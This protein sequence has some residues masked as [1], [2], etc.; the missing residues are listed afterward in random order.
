MTVAVSAMTD[1]F[2]V[3]A[4]PLHP[5]DPD[6]QFAR[7]LRA[8][9]ERALTLPRGVAVSAATTAVV[10]EPSI[11][12]TAGGAVPYLA[13]EDARTAID[14][15]TEVLGARR[16]GE[17]IV[18]PDGRVGHAALAVGAGVLYL[19]DAHPEIG[20][21]APTPG[22]STVSLMLEVDD[23]DA[24]LARALNRGAR[25]DR[26]VYE[27]YGHRNAWIVDPFGH[28]WCLQG[29]ILTSAAK[30]TIQHGDVGYLMWQTPDVDA[31]AR[32]YAQ[33]LGWQ[34]RPGSVPDGRR[35]DNSPIDIG[36]WGGQAPSTAYPC[37]A[38]DSVDA[39]VVAV[40]AAGGTADEP[41]DAPH[42]RTADCV[43]DQGLGFVVYEP[44]PDA[45]RPV[46]D[47]PGNVSYLSFEVPSAEAA[48]AF[49]GAVLGWRP[50]SE[51]QWTA[52]DPVPMHGI[53]GNREPCVVP[54]WK[55]E[56]IHAAVERVRAG[57]GTASDPEPRPYGWLAECT[58]DQGG[59]FY[60]GDW[61]ER[62]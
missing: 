1:P 32:F 54:M 46:F 6:P 35:V 43:D 23:T 21:V 14:W 28:R 15:Y 50:T 45:P 40:R 53:A 34:V 8:R 12:A 41:Q 42:G 20:V 9:L 17:P 22:Q 31:A 60:L 37:F 52:R 7:R 2:D 25:Q 47:Q 10:R 27:D 16:V 49:Y 61:S 4:E 18:M 56:D 11:A 13:V 51:D 59:R 5:V 19:A 3:L 36:L 30:Q 57:G 26:E 24:R 44:A 58:D 48:Q 62:G 38:V 39:A 55:V 29:P 33:V